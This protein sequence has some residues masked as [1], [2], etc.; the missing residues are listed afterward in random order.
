MN[1]LVM[2]VNGQT[3]TFECHSHAKAV[4]IL[5]SHWNM[6]TESSPLSVPVVESFELVQ[7][8]HYN[9]QETKKMRALEIGI[10]AL[11]VFTFSALPFVFI[12]GADD[13]KDEEV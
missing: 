13:K 1:S 4:E 5:A 7:I 2:K 8:T 11:A 6:W 3:Y 10:Y 12:F 9:R